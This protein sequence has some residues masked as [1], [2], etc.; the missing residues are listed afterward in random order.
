MH[1]LNDNDS[2]LPHTLA[3]VTIFTTWG[4]LAQVYALV[5]SMCLS[6]VAVLL[7]TAKH[8]ITQ[9]MSHDSDRDSSFLMANISMKFVWGHPQWG[10]WT[11]VGWV[12]H[13]IL[14]NN[15]L[16]LE[17]GAILDK[18]IVSV[19]V[20]WEIICT[21]YRMMALPITL[22]YPT[23]TTAYTR[24]I[25]MSVSFS[26]NPLPVK[27]R[28]HSLNFFRAFLVPAITTESQLV[29]QHSAEASWCSI[30]AWHTYISNVHQVY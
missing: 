4:M 10:H 3:Y 5:L 29:Y 2:E 13:H 18:R 9:T 16:Y 25:C 22:S 20:E 28:K 1:S 30:S 19:K 21:V 17:N 14:S 27:I 6:Q 23:C 24:C 15:L 12:S 11:Q 26:K 8:R 7:K